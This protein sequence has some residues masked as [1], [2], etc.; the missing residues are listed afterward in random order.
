MWLRIQIGWHIVKGPLQGQPP[1]LSCGNVGQRSSPKQYSTYGYMHIPVGIHLWMDVCI[2][3]YDRFTSTWMDGVNVLYIC[4]LVGQEKVFT[5]TEYSGHTYMYTPTYIGIGHSLHER[6]YTHTH[7]LQRN[8]HN[9]LHLTKRGCA[10]QYVHRYLQV[11]VDRV[12]YT[13]WVWSCPCSTRWGYSSELDR[14]K[15]KP[16]LLPIQLLQCSPV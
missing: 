9:T 13:Y 7:N 2:H 10:S 5:G 6:K 8:T 15:K 12:E 14:L 1:G 11:D 16:I 3:L 4:I